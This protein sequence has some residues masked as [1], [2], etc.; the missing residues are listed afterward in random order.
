[1]DIFTASFLCYI[2]E[3]LFVEFSHHGASVAVA[4]HILAVRDGG[5][6]GGADADGEDEDA[7]FVQLAGGDEGI[8]RVVLAIGDED[9]G[10]L[11]EGGCVAGRLL[12]VI[13]QRDAQGSGGA[14][15]G[16]GEVGAL[17]G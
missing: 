6:V 13:F 9:N 11:D 10:F 17:Y 5:S 1:M 3:Y 4:F 16:F 14:V 8:F 2:F 7:V 15:Q 12:F